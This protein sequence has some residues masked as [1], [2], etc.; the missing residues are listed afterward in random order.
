VSA[1]IT[2][3]AEENVF[4]DEFLPGGS[5]EPF[6]SPTYVPDFKSRLKVLESLVQ[7]L[8]D[9]NKMGFFYVDWKTTQWRQVGDERSNMVLLDVEEA[10]TFSHGTVFMPF[11]KGKWNKSQRKC[12]DKIEYMCDARDIVLQ[13]RK[14]MDRVNM[15]NVEPEIL[16]FFTMP[17]EKL[18]KEDCA[19]RALFTQR[20]KFENLF[21]ITKQKS[22]IFYAYQAF[23][24]CPIINEFLPRALLPSVLEENVRETLLVDCCDVV[25]PPSTLDILHL[26]QDIGEKY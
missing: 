21:N 25:D 5:L 14:H 12:A 17:V 22:S 2:Y 10:R 13:G 26:I 16:E 9:I 6:K 1:T 15:T 4:V 7:S 23:R 20:G 8:V 19:Y 3:C 18:P 24:I 11:T